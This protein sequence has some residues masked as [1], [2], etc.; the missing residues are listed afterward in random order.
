M[1]ISFPSNPTTGQ[2]FTDATS[3]NQYEWNG[4]VWIG[5]TPITISGNFVGIGSTAPLFPLTVGFSTLGVDPIAGA[6]ATSLYVQGSVT[7]T[8]RLTAA[9]VVGATTFTTMPSGDLG[10]FST[11]SADSFGVTL[12]A[13]YDLKVD[14]PGAVINADLGSL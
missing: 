11:P 7:V 12:A 1:A 9:K 5:K 4:T 10:D 6:A 8:D 13:N 14:P 2:V 3:G